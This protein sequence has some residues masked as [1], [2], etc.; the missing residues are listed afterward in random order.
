M[1]SLIQH[2]V[3]PQ[4]EV[5][6]QIADCS[7][8]VRCDPN[9]LE[10]ALLNLA[11]N[12]RDAMPAGGELTIVTKHARLE[13]GDTG[14]WDNAAP[15]EYVCITVRDTGTG[16]PPDVIEHA[17]EP[18]FT[19]KPDGQGTGLGLSQLHGFVCQSNGAVR[20]ESALGAGTSVH[21]YLP[22]CTEMMEAAVA[23][24]ASDTQKMPAPAREGGSI[25][26]VDDEHTVRSF[27]AETLR[28][29][30]YRVVEAE[31]GPAGLKAL[32]DA[33]RAP[34][35]DHVR[36]LVT[37][38]GLPGGLNGR[39]LADA[40]REMSPHLP[41]LLI[42]GYAGDAAPGRKQLARGMEMLAKPFELDVLARRVQAMIGHG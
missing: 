11:I 23:A 10:N 42:T 37:D 9:Q 28:E 16:M 32:R 5:S 25:V 3:G 2:T 26:L 12:A 41:I 14:P 35:N 19:T 39:Q 31:D 40:A 36:L 4:I 33:L 22:R 20:L 17:F 13:A 34:A 21:M 7:W 18:F 29:M 38:V 24:E 30:G 8:P 27:A 15:G 1:E 6:L